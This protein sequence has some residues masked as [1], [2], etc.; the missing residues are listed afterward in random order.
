MKKTFLTQKKTHKKLYTTEIA[1]INKN[2][3]ETF[4]HRKIVDNE[5]NRLHTENSKASTTFFKYFSWK[6][7]VG[8]F[9]SSINYIEN[10]FY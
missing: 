1:D 5:K 9:I 10:V 8:C 3:F 7:K 4:L 6:V 2:I